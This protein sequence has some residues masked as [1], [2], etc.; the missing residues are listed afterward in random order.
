M[1]LNGFLV[2]NSDY[3]MLIQ[4]AGLQNDFDEMHS[5]DGVLMLTRPLLLMADIGGR[6]ESQAL[7]SIS[8]SLA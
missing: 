4:A 6:Q 3:D 8:K 7:A 1:R 2:C 5:E